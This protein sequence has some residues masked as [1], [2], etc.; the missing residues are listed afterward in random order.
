V[1]F[2]QHKG[3]PKRQAKTHSPTVDDGFESGVELLPVELYCHDA[4]GDDT[5]KEV[6]VVRGQGPHA[7]EEFV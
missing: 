7:P 1:S 5:L 2:E 3:K 6:M 4:T